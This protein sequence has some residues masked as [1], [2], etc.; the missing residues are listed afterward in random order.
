MK[1]LV[2]RILLASL[3]AALPMVVIAADSAP[4]VTI[5]LKNRHGHCTPERC[6]C[7]H[8]G[9]G[10]IDVQQPK[11][12]TLVITLTGVAVAAPHPSRSRA[13]MNFDVQQCFEVVFAD[14]KVKR[15]KVS[16]DAQVIGLLRSHKNSAAAVN[17]GTAAVSGGGHQIV[18]IALEPHS[19][20]GGENLSINDHPCP[21]SA[22]IVAGDFHYS[23]TFCISAEHASAILGKAASAEFAPDPALDPL[24]ISYWEPFRGAQKKDF[25]FRVTMK[26]EPDDAAAPASNGNGNGNALPVPMPAAKEGEKKVSL[27]TSR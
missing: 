13:V 3:A 26:V 6:G 1:T 20:C 14:E 25:G 5:S 22:P 21:V 18:G 16:L 11:D 15:A 17:N 10:N 9:G 4:K 23:Q 12:D 24:W 7:T 8:T 27:R 2:Q 19:V